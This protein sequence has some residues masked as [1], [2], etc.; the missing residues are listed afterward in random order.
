MAVKPIALTIA[1]S[2]PSGGAGIQGD[3]KTFAAHGVYGAAVIAAL[4]VQNTVGVT[5]AIG[6]DPVFVARQATAVLDDLPVGAVKTGMLFDAAIIGA[7]AAIFST[8]QEIPLVVDPVMVSTSGHRLLQP[9]AVTAMKER[10]VPLATVVTPNGPEAFDLTGIEVTD[11]TS[12][13]EAAKKIVAMGPRGVVIKG[14]HHRQGEHAVDILLFD[15]AFF[16]FERPWIETA[17]TH[18]S[19]CAFASAIT[20]TLAGGLSVPDAVAQAETFIG[21]AIEHAYRIGGGA[22]SPVNHAP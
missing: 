15:G 7:V 2:D 18:G 3:L 14:G 21:R 17:Y 4:T 20:A 19:G 11:E 8:R 6:V 22:N 16:R 12:M 13:R 10:L 5:D 9:D 1:G